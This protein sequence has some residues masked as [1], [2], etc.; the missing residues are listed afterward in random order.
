MRNFR[1]ALAAVAAVALVSATAA[2]AATPKPVSFT[3]KYSGTASTK[4]AEGTTTADILANGTGT[5]T[6]IGAGKLAGKGTADSSVQPCV[7]FGGLTTITGKSGTI[8]L[9][10]PVSSKGC[11]DEGGH[12]FTLKGTATVV[13]ATGKL[14]KA[15]G[16]LKFT[17]LYDRDGGTFSV[18]FTGLLKK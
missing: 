7:P 14:A 10:V 5:G 11:G 12:V 16:V 17:G 6:L 9:K 4:V 2:L 8:Q 1:Y 3:G 15:K 13:K 18:K